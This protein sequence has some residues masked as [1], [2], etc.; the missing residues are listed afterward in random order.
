VVLENLSLLFGQLGF[1]A[2]WLG[3]NSL[4]TWLV[5]SGIL[6]VWKVT[7]LI[8]VIGTCLLVKN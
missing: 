5:K 7:T 3:T 4:S 2:K 1:N 6:S 8:N